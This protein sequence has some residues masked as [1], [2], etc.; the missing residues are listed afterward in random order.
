MT[1]YYRGPAGTVTE[2]H[3]VTHA[4][5]GSA[6]DL[7]DLRNIMRVRRR[8]PR[9]AAVLAAAVAVI[10]AGVAVGWLMSDMGSLL[11]VLVAV[12]AAVFVLRLASPVYTLRADHRDQPVELYSTRDKVDFE[13][14]CRNLERALEDLRPA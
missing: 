2:S 11:V 14:V 8:G 6:Y 5:D 4:P 10:L 1:V 3:F 9:F 12:V 13:R 7:N